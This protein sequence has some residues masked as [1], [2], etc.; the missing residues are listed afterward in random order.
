[1]QTLNISITNEQYSSVNKLMKK[2]GFANRSEFFR[3][4]LRNLIKPFAMT[5]AIKF[6][7]PLTKNPKTII[8][9]FQKTGQYSEKFLSSLKKGLQESRYF[10]S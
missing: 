3:S 5:P 4:L 10:N 6:Q 9:A 8:N 2:W 7:K 1:M